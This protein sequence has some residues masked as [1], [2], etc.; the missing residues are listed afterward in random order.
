MKLKF[1][2]FQENDPVSEKATFQ[3]INLDKEIEVN[4]SGRREGARHR[5]QE[6]LRHNWP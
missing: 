6:R 5:E 4:E 2:Q 3:C 1:I